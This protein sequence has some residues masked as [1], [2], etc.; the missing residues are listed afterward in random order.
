M[1]FSEVGVDVDEEFTSTSNIQKKLMQV[2]DF[3]LI[4]F[5]DF[6]RI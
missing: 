1:N 4:S 3:V 6:F 2:T 5:E